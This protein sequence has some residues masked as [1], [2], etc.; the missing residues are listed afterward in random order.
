MAAAEA[1]LDMVVGVRGCEGAVGGVAARASQR[2]ETLGY[3]SEEI[4]RFL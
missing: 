4:L 1:R 3:I 2:V